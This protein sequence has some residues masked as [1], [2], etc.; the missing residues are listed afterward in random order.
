MGIITAGTGGWIAHMTP[1]LNSQ[2]RSSEDDLVPSS[3]AMFHPVRGWTQTKPAEGQLAVGTL[4]GANSEFSAP[5]RIAGESPA[6]STD[7]RSSS[8]RFVTIKP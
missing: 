6:E 4:H 3:W 1:A 8:L 2:N 7:C 5:R